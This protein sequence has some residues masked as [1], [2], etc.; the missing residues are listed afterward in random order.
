VFF[1]HKELTNL[2]LYSC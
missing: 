2:L 1:K